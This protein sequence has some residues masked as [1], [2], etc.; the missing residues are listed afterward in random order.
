MY[1]ASSAAALKMA[2]LAVLCSN[3]RLARHYGV[4]GAEGGDFRRVSLRPEDHRG[5]LLTQAG[6]LSL[7]SDGTRHRPVHRGKWVMVTV[8]GKAPPPP[9]PNR[10]FSRAGRDQVSSV[11]V[12]EEVLKTLELVGHHFKKRQVRVEPEF[13]PAVPIIQADRQHLR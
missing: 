7:T 8:Y 5:G 3:A 6:V 2:L 11:D 1:R 9:P 13:D 12:T 10:Q 4:P